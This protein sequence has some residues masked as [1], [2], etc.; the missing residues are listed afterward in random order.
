M[1]PTYKVAYAFPKFER[2]FE[3]EFTRIKALL[4]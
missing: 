4:K 3:D 1:M 2:F